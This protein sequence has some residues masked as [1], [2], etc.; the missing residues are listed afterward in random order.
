M[1]DFLTRLIERS[2]G[3]APG[4]QR[5]EPLI[6]PLYTAGPLAAQILDE[7]SIVESDPQP[8]VLALRT[9][10]AAQQPV[11]KSSPQD[12][13][14]N[15]HLTPEITPM[16]TLTDEPQSAQSHQTV[17][18]HPLP[19]PTP[20]ATLPQAPLVNARP[21]LT[22]DD[23]DQSRRANIQPLMIRP[24]VTRADEAN[25]HVNKTA[26]ETSGETAA[27]VIRVTIGRI[28]LRAVNAPT[29]PARRQAPSAPKLSLDEY[30]RSRNGR[31][32]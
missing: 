3:V 25:S 6:A 18:I 4:G 17:S 22:A 16:R 14:L 19:P 11:Q 10:K 24:Q 26:N 21:G 1:A 32:G 30:L 28:D 13:E 8:Q 15:D 9:G 20:N 27:P 29:P 23:A 12:R 2:R 5:V 7:D 31:K